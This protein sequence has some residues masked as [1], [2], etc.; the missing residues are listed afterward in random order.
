[1]LAAGGSSID[2][3]DPEDIQPSSVDLHLAREVPGVPQLALPVHRSVAWS[4]AGLMD[5]VEASAEEPFVLHPGEFVLG[6]TIERV[7]L[8]RRHRRAPRG[9]ELARQARAAHPLDRRLRRS[10]LGRDAHARVVERRESADRAHSGHG[11]RADL[12]HAD[13]DAR[14]APL[15]LARVSAARYQGQV[16]P[17]P[18]R[19]YR[20]PMTGVRESR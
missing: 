7:A 15:R 13:D 1:M 17:T 18:S 2:P 9:Q 12:V 16:E 8:P 3:C 6:A 4:S 11:H 19:S 20:P 14:G 10:G 5:L